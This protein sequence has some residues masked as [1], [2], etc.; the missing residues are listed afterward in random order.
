MITC[1]LQIADHE[2]TVDAFIVVY[3]V[4]DSS[5]FSYAHACLQDTQMERFR[6]TVVILVANKQDLVRNKVITEEGRYD[7]IAVYT[8]HTRI[9]TLSY[10]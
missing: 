5:S 8:A 4:T 9:P 10:T 1:C 6:Q 7:R 2:K 3:S